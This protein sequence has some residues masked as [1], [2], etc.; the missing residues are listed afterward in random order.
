[1]RERKYIGVSMSE[2]CLINL[3]E[4]ASQF[5]SCESAQNFL[6]ENSVDL[7][8]YLGRETN[9]VEGFHQ[10]L[11]QPTSTAV[12]KYFLDFWKD[13]SAHTVDLRQSVY[14]LIQPQRTIYI[15]PDTKETTSGLVYLVASVMLTNIGVLAEKKEELQMLTGQGDISLSQYEE[16]SSKLEYSGLLLTD[17]VSH[18][19]RDTWSVNES[20]PISTPYK[21]AGHLFISRLVNGML[22]PIQANW[23]H[24]SSSAYCEKH[25]EDSYSCEFSATPINGEI[26][27][28]ELIDR[29]KK[30]MIAFVSSQTHY[31]EEFNRDLLSTIKRAVASHTLLKQVAYEI[32]R[33]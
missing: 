11:L 24:T 13:D 33:I 19:C 25:P 28:R 6:T 15:N 21:S 4:I 32:L 17:I 27:E 29:I 5:L 2:T 7:C 30:W 10:C 26:T 31:T 3:H 18:D 22:H 16:V 12:T 1:M 8:V 20:T 23:F 14:Y 9:I